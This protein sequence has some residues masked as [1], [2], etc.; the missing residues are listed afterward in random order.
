MQNVNGQPRP[1][2]SPKA[3]YANIGY[4]TKVLTFTIYTLLLVLILPTFYNVFPLIHEPTLTTVDH[5][6]HALKCNPTE[7][8]LL[9]NLISDCGALAPIV[10]TLSLIHSLEA[11]QFYL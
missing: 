10:D 4:K 6:S 2:Y 9:L 5:D 1:E 11:F 3:L 7:E 8:V